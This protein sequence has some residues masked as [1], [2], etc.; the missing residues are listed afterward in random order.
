MILVTGTSGSLG[1]LIH[2]RLAAAGAPVVAGSRTPPDGGRRVDL[3][4]PGSLADAFAGI[5][6]LVLVSA[7]YAEDDV[8]VARHGAAIE[9]AARSGVRHVFYTS[10]SG[11]GDRMTIA[12]PHRWTESALA[13]APPAWTVLRN[14]IYAEFAAGLAAAGTRVAVDEGV[15]RLPWGQGSLPVVAREDLAEAAARVAREAQQAIDGGE[16]SPH[17]GRTYELEGLTSVGGAD[18]A[19]ALAEA[20]GRPVRYQP[21]PLGET[22]STLAAAGAAPYQIAHAVSLYSNVGAGFTAPARSDL[23]DLLEA[24]PRSARELIVSA[25]RE[26]AAA[27]R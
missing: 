8:V 13:A 16:P 23:P 19:D 14:G 10:L 25:A 17:A 9:A 4:D 6:V 15:F 1:G 3:D 27:I 20:T 26:S 21:S 24:P 5:D 2:R 7:G 11:S 12:L 18:L 22:W